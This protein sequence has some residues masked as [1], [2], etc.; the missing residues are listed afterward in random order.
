[1]AMSPRSLFKRNIRPV[2]PESFPSYIEKEIDRLGYG[3]N[4]I[5]QALQA[6]EARVAAL[7]P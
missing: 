7:E 2:Q 3:H 6:L 5:I 4:N 1:M